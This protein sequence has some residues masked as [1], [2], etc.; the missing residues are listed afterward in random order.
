MQFQ[1]GHLKVNNDHF[2]KPLIKVTCTRL[3]ESCAL[4]LNSRL[5]TMK[6]WQGNIDESPI[7]L[8]I[9]HQTLKIKWS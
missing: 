7:V 5:F 9:W 6:E 1:N 3:K 4:V 2:L 8:V